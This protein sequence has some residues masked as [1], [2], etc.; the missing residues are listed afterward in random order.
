MA[1]QALV[2]FATDAFELKVLVLNDTQFLAFCLRLQRAQDVYKRKMSSGH[3]QWK[4][5]AGDAY[6]L[7]VCETHLGA[8]SVDYQSEQYVFKRRNDGKLKISEF[9]L[10]P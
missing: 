8:S 4:L 3:D 7:L 9:L 2:I 5:N 6:K 1:F 10:L